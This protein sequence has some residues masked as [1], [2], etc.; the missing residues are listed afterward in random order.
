MSLVNINQLK[1]EYSV[2][3]RFKPELKLDQSV[4]IISNAYPKKHFL[5][6]VTYISPSV[7]KATRSIAIQAVVHNDKKLLSPGMFVQVAQTLSENKKALVIPAQ[8]LTASIQ[9]Y[10]VYKV[11][12]SKAELTNVGVGVRKD[13]KAQI[14]KGLSLGDTVVIAGQQKLQDGSPVKIVEDSKGDAN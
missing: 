3:Q 8:A 10:Q 9:G 6:T 5:G 2:P 1:A 7:N 14:L 4:K 13:G 12:D 11:V